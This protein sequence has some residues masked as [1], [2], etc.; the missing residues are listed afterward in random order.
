MTTPGLQVRV[1]RSLEGEPLLEGQLDALNMASRRPTPFNGRDFLRTFMQHDEFAG[2]DQ[3]IRLLAAVENDRLVGFLP[4]RK[5]P[6]QALGRTEAKL[7]FYIT[8][9]NDRPTLVA[10]PEDEA[11]CAAAFW[12]HL[13][14]GPRDWSI[15]ELSNV[16][17]G[18]ALLQLPAKKAGA[19]ARVLD[20]APTAI[21]PT[22]QGDVKVWYESLKKSWRHT[23]GRLGRKL[24]GA[25]NVE[26]VSCHDVRASHRLLDLYLDLERRSWK[27]KH[28]VGRTPERIALH[29]RLC[30][31]DSEF[32][33]SF[34]FVLLD[35][36]II[37][38]MIHGDFPGVLY[39]METCYDDA[40]EKL[41]PGHLIYLMSIR[42]AILRGAP[43]LNEFAD[44]A[45]YK[46][47][48]G[49]ELVPTKTLQVF[50]FG[51][52][53]WLKARLGEIKRR[54]AGSYL[55]RKSGR[56]NTV[57]RTVEESEGEGG[58]AAETTET[59]APARDAERALA[60]SVL[61][62]LASEGVA[63]ERL[64]GPELVAALPYPGPKPPK[65]AQPQPQRQKQRPRR[66]RR[67]GAERPEGSGPE[68]APA[69]TEAG[70]QAAPAQPGTEP[71]PGTDGSGGA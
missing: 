42:E 41:G 25:G 40:Y 15:I 3:E 45:Y 39:G 12:H 68:Q 1:L 53:H 9:D 23:V 48:W 8:H 26:V 24:L 61:A 49:A 60:S 66:E 11:R 20:G 17:D 27:V 70:G 30:E 58:E 50:R 28:G 69:G 5:R 46:A 37:A 65:Q 14:A 67:E 34:Q 52:A 6:A 10:R 19:Y 43:S 63:L 31:P 18:A 2:P 55:G 64:A 71:P 47:Y 32:K 13:F 44:F 21:I 54:L 16:E 56:F 62:A 38:G 59:I 7:E 35:G 22:N 57:K 36:V 4:L 29:R 33:L 51:S